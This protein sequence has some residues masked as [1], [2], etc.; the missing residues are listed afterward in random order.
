[1][2]AVLFAAGTLARAEDAGKG[3]GQP[4]KRSIITVTD[5][6]NDSAK[7]K[8]TKVVVVGMFM[9]NDG[10]CKRPSP[11]QNDWMIQDKLGA[12][13]WARGMFPEG[14]VAQTKIGVGRDVAVEGV[15]TIDNSVPVLIST[16]TQEVVAQ[17]ERK[18]AE[19]LKQKR[20][21]I[22]VQMRKARRAEEPRKILTVGEVAHNPIVFKDKDLFVKGEYYPEKGKCEG[23]A[24]DKDD[25]MLRDLYGDCMY[26][27][28]PRPERDGKELELG[29]LL[30]ITAVVK[31]K[32]AGGKDA[33]YLERLPEKNS[34]AGK[35][36]DKK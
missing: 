35:E 14:C 13:M 3:A 20:A 36:E 21:D 23:P 28:G 15:L 17:Q 8:G 12:C 24:P 34:D 7:Y 26:V 32:T 1:M 4:K 29:A 33:Y 6:V 9:G 25:W 2:A 10:R 30:T 11:K 22:V 19:I 31:K 16:R 5:A 27:H 18:Q